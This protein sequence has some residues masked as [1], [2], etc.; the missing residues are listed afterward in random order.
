MK[1]NGLSALAET[2]RLAE[3]GCL[4]GD[5]GQGPGPRNPARQ[6]YQHSPLPPLRTPGCPELLHVRLQPAGLGGRRTLT[7]R[8][9]VPDSV[10]RSHEPTWV[11]RAEYPVVAPIS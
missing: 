2:P 1:R 3:G 4:A 6:R 9:P 11:P 5:T 7:E 10:L 8:S